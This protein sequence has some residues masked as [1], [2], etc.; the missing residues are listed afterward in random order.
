ME[1][2]GRKL[3]AVQHCWVIKNGETTKVVEGIV[4]TSIYQ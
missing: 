2:N 3:P 1:Y 4:D